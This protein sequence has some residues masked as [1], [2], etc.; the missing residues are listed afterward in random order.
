VDSG[1]E[2]RGGQ[3]QLRLLLRGL[4]RQARIRQALLTRRNSRIAAE[5]AGLGLPI[6]PVQWRGA[7][8]GDAVASLVRRNGSDW[9][10][11]HAH[12]GHAVQSVLLARGLAGGRSPVV[13]ARRVDFAPRK[14]SVWQRADLVIA[15]SA[16]IRDVL[17]ENG[18]DRSRVEVVHSGIE[19]S[20]L[21][22][23]AGVLRAAAGASP[24]ELLVAAV[25]ALVP[26]KDHATFVRAAALVGARHPSVRFAVFGEGSERKRL[27]RMIEELGL[28]DRFR[29]VGE[30]P[31]A[32]RSLDDIDVFVMPSR[33]EGLGTACIEAMHA[34]RPVV[35]TSAGGIGELAVDGSFDPVEPENPGAL[36]AEIGRLVESAEA[37]E[38]AG[39][40]ALAGAGRFTADAMV[41]G[42]LRCYRALSRRPWEAS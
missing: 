36:A 14:P 15:V 42:T 22:P 32:A 20:E 39:R 38:E 8:D 11:I 41:S 25:G 37:R 16:R 7:V 1:R 21:E 29:L 34:G 19:P 35:A 31:G 26:H 40:T 5:A 4:A 3:N 30:V 12:D 23:A 13:A 18:I 6:F 28:A 10:L 24:G 33:E 2:Y 17:V 9:D 27:T